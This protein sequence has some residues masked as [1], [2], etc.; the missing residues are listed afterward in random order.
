VPRKETIRAVQLLAGTI[1]ASLYNVPKPKV[2]SNDASSDGSRLEPVVI[3]A[4]WRATTS[5]TEQLP[6]LHRHFEERARPPFPIVAF[7]SLARVNPDDSPVLLDG[8]SGE[9]Y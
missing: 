6:P 4:H 8:P 7:P 3:Q 5:S 1:L 2:S 9:A